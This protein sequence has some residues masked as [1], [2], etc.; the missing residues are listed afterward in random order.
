MPIVFYP[1]IN[2]FASDHRARYSF[3][4]RKIKRDDGGKFARK[5]SREAH[6]H[7]MAAANWGGEHSGSYQ[8]NSDHALKGSR[9]AI[10]ASGS[11]SFGSARA[12][13]KE[14]AQRHKE[15]ADH[16]ESLGYKDA[17]A[18]HHAAHVSH[19]TAHEAYHNFLSQ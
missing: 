17:A 16:E 15:A 6:G 7:S 19:T 2:Q 3:E 14:T 8:G 18:M 10:D 11:K 9:H 12:F 4:E 5:A 1:Q 13:H